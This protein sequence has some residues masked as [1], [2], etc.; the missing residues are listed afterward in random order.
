MNN[1]NDIQVLLEQKNKLESNLN[2]LIYGSVEIREQNNNKY[3]YVHY[4]EDG[5]L[6]SKYVDEYSDN[7]YNLI[8]KNNIEAKKIKR[9]LNSI[10]KNL[11]KFEYDDSKELSDIIKQ[12]LDFAKRNLV[13]TIYKQAMLEG[14]A[15]TFADTEIIVEGGKVS[16]M[17]PEDIIKI[18]NLKH[19]WEFILS[20]GVITYEENFNLLS[21]INKLVNEGLYYNAGKIRDIPVRIGGT[22]WTPPMPIESQIVEE[23]RELLQSPIDGVD[24]AIEI[25]LFVMK[26]QIFIDGN[27][28]TAVIFANHFSISR[29]LGIIAIPADLT[30]E[31]KKMLIHYYE[32]SDENSIKEFLKNTSYQAM[33]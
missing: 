25:L 27:K 9:E 24:L 11:K 13:D 12:N 2:S 22:D 1:S 3:I 19:A 4:R 10:K 5:R 14:V 32:G 29:G 7:L 8:L 15:T 23:L 30:E 6:Q 26:K 16:G 20:E 17:T 18:V 31:Y 33:S 21:Q 28:R